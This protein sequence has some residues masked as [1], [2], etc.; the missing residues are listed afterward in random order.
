AR[1]EGRADRRRVVAEDREVVHHQ[2]VAAG[3]ADHR[4]DSGRSFHVSYV[5]SAFKRTIRRSVRLQPDL[6]VRGGRAEGYYLCD[7]LISS[8]GDAATSQEDGERPHAAGALGSRALMVSSTQGRA[9]RAAARP[10]PA[11][12]E[13][14]APGIARLPVT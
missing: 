3:D 1:E 9:R 4:P 2:K 8:V 5:V 7:Y 6:Q 14:Q 11:A 13:S 10:H 12:K